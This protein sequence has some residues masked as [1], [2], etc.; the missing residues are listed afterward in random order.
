MTATIPSSTTY[1]DLIARAVRLC[2]AAG[3][4]DFNG[5]VS[6][7]D[8]DDR[9]V[10]WI[11]NR[12]ASRSTLTALDVVPYDIAA[13]R[14]LGEGIEPPSEHWIHREIYLRR[15]DV[16]GIVH[17][18]PEYIL[19]LSAA[20]HRLRQ[21]VTVNPFIPD[22]GAPVF[23]TPVLINTEARGTALAAA[24]GEHPIV[25][26]RQHG[27][28]T[29]GTSTEEAVIRMICAEDNARCQY[30]ALQIGTPNYIDGAEAV[31]LRKDNLDPKIIRKFW[32]YWEETAR[33]AGRLEGLAGE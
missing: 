1:G 16:G 13:G 33:R 11:N 10:M 27:T 28:V 29:V 14:R 31:T 6:V 4:M 25:V 7:R 12:H 26:L 21:V 2:N 20:G 15:F 17:S 23:D 30:R 18:H 8:A 9:N 22:D 5:H 19:T 3:V 32:T 24:L